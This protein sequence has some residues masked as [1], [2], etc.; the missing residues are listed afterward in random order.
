MG[1]PSLTVTNVPGSTSFTWS[2][3]D[4]V[5]FHPEI[6]V[7]S[8][9]AYTAQIAPLP[10]WLKLL[11]KPMAMRRPKPLI[12]TNC[13]SL[14]TDR[15][16]PFWKRSDRRKVRI[17]GNNP[18]CFLYRTWSRLLCC[19]GSQSEIKRN[20]HPMWRLLLRVS[21]NTV[22]SL[23]T[24]RVHRFT[25]SCLDPVLSQ[26]H[27]WKYPRSSSTGLCFNHCRRKCR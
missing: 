9:K 6:A 1:I 14:P 18:Q 2:R 26:P 23:W 5:K 24:K 3:H 22:L 19:Y 20:L 11:G 21:W 16:N 7:A 17:V 4:Y 8:T 15:I 12:C 10:F 27:T 25:L 13:L